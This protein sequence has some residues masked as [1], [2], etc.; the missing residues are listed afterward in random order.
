MAH[1]PLP[2]IEGEGVPSNEV[3]HGPVDDRHTPSQSSNTDPSTSL[4]WLVNLV[5]AVILVIL[6]LVPSIADVA[7][8]NIPDWFAH[9]LALLPGLG[10]RGSLVGGLLGATLFGIGTEGLQLL[11][12]ARSVE[13]K[14]L[15]AN[16]VVA[17]VACGILAGASRFG[18]RGGE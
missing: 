1:V 12:P 10:R 2:V 18:S 6:A 9:A 7:G 4:R 15:A 5:Y 3:D 13:M 11:H 17:L 16:T 8:L 14:D